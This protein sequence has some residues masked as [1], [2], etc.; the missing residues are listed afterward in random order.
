[1]EHSAIVIAACWATV[2]WPWPEKW[3]WCAQAGPLFTKRKR[4]KRWL[5]G[6][7]SSNLP[8]KS[9]EVRKKPLLSGVNACDPTGGAVQTLWKSLH[10][11]LT[12]G[13]KSLAALG[14][15]TCIS[16]MPSQML[17]QGSY[18]P[19][20]VIVQILVWPCVGAADAEIKVPSGENTE[21]K[22]SPF[23][24]WSR[25]VYSHTCYAYCQGFLPYFYTSSPFT[26]I[27]FKTS[28]HFSYVGCG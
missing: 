21:L 15:Q 5:A 2:D 25:L 16:S 12:V 27:F 1:M 18:I 19:T 9:S 13:E 8:P 11:E 6:T 23:K 17:K 7:Q 28:P 10:S 3:N 4:E 26:C 20:P 14:S 22:R 24:A